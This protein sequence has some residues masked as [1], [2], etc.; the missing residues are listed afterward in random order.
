M[1]L[2]L[3]YIL[4]GNANSGKTC[5][6]WRYK[7]DEFY[8]SLKSTVGVDVQTKTYPMFNNQIKVLLWDTA[9]Q[10]KFHSLSCAFYR[11]SICVFL[12]FDHTNRKSFMDISKWLDT[13]LSHLPKYAQIVLVGL[14]NDMSF[15]VTHEEAENFAKHHNMKYYSVSAKTGHNIEK[16]FRQISEE[17][18]IDYLNGRISISANSGG[19]RIQNSKQQKQRFR[20]KCIW[21]W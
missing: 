9:G 20:Y 13:M 21:P 7:F 8:D 6:A 4:I 12:C 17:I 3:K 11:D 10:E 16:M 5:L 1:K 15:K 14:K 19:I 18:Y 2:I